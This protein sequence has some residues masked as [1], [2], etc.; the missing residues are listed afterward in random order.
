MTLGRTGELAIFVAVLALGRPVLVPVALAFYLAFVLTPPSNGLERLGVPRFLSV[1]AV[2]G[3]ALAIVGVLGTVLVAQAADLH[4]Q[5]TT[6]ALQM[7]HKLSGLR[8]GK[9][10][11]LGDLSAAFSELGRALDPALGSTT[12]ATPV[13]LVV[14]G[15]STYHRLEEALGPLLQP[16][17]LVTIVFVLAVFMLGHREDLRGRLIQLVG[18]QNLTVATRTMAEAVNRVGRVLLTQA[19]I[20]AGFGAVLAIGL[21][22]IGTPYALLWGVIAAMLRFVPLLGALVAALL[23]T[24]VAF[25]VFPGWQSAL[26]TLG[27]V[28]VVETVVSNFIEPM[29]LGKRTGVSALALLISALFWTWLWGPAGLVLATP[30]TVCAAVVGRHVPDWAFLSI[31]LGDEVGLNPEVN[32]YQRTLAR[33]SKDAYRFAKRLAGETSLAQT[34]DNVVV[35]ALGLMVHDLNV[36]AISQLDAD[37]VVADVSDIVSRLAP[38]P[39]RE[40]APAADRRVLG[41][42]AES[43][44]DLLLLQMLHFTLAEQSA[45]L[46]PVSQLNRAD[47]LAAAI[48]A[49][50]TLVCLAAL[51]PSANV[52]ARFLCRRLRAA[53]PNAYIVVL[54]PEPESHRSKEA[55][56]RLREAGANGIAS[57]L[58]EA[59][60]LLTTGA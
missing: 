21:Y 12:T 48:H 59:T 10:G 20:N 41:I 6:Y 5:M 25:A 44:A 31:A 42:A 32:F 18:P 54:M 35:P 11:A 2:V 38:P 56:A 22:I 4:R 50:P 14:G 55:A 49:A 26:L 52:N 27:L 24:L 7:S 29:V 9:L 1:A 60:R 13:R 46:L 28:L 39:L 34:L 40:N 45:R 57:S 51:P 16:L 47:A 37:R 19:Y 15:Q 3:G 30:I 53:L 33:V 8:A 23:P 58:R 43:N 36:E 17:G